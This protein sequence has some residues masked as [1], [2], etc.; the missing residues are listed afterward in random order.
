MIMITTTPKGEIN[1]NLLRLQLCIGSNPGNF[2][3]KSEVLRLFSCL[4]VTQ[5]SK[6]DWQHV[7]DKFSNM[8]VHSS[9]YYFVM[10]QCG[11]KF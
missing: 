5:R 7:N 2:H 10:S 8:Y 4:K 6:L 3:I 11:G 9:A 1:Y